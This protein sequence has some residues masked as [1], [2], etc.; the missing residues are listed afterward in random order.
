MVR[1]ATNWKGTQC[2]GYEAKAQYVTAKEALRKQFK[3]KLH[4]TEFRTRARR[5]GE[6]R[7]ELADN[8]RLL[9]DKAF[10]EL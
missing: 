5:H 4:M 6:S 9:A 10:P 3:R 7:E 8:V 1:G 2:L